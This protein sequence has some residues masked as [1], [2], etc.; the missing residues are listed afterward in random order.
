MSVLEFCE[1]KEIIKDRMSKKRYI[2][3]LNVAKAAEHLAKKYG[4]DVKKAKTAGI[5]HDITK[6]TPYD[7]Q[8][9]IIK[10]NG[11]MLNSIQEISP[12]T[13]HAISGCLYVEK[14]LGI[15]DKDILNAIRYHTSGRA[16]MSLLEKV[17]FVA[18]F[19]GDERDYNG[20]EIMRAKAERSLEEAMLYGVSFSIQDLTSHQCAVDINTFA[21]YN[22]LIINQNKDNKDRK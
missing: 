16:G 4:A 1:Y 17:I 8:L 2:H 10:S 11:I 6:E 20:V 19:V 5:L 3:S 14:N 13:W 22:E 21:L 18:D 12:K 15:T 7:Q 9:Q